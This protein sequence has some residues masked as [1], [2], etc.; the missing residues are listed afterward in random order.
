VKLT[1]LQ[2]DLLKLDHL[3]T[4]DVS[5][6]RDKI[7]DA[8]RE[9]FEAQYVLFVIMIIVITFPQYPFQILLYRQ[10]NEKEKLSKNQPERMHFVLRFERIDPVTVMW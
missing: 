3:L 1:Q 8:S 9:F 2:Q 4:V 5:I 10:I 6:I 7:E